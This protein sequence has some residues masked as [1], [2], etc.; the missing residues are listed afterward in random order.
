M[1]DL[2]EIHK[3]SEYPTDGQM[4]Q[5]FI[6]GFGVAVTSVFGLWDGIHE[7]WY[8]RDL[9][10]EIKDPK[11]WCHVNE[12]H[13]EEVPELFEGTMNALNNLTITKRQ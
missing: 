12:W 9:K 5:I 3:P 8:C 7:K 2:Y 6:K 4:K 1:K 13:E 11:G 10:T